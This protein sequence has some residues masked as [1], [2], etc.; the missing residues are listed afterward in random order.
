MI[1]I[2]KTGRPLSV[3]LLV[4]ASLLAAAPAAAANLLDGAR[5]ETPDRVK[6]ADNL[7]DGRAPREGDHWKTN[8]TATLDPD[9]PTIVYDLGAERD[10]RAIY[11]QGDNNDRYEVAVSN[12]GQQYSVVWTAPQLKASGMRGRAAPDL[13]ARGRY[14]R[15]RASGGDRAYAIG[16]LQ[17]FDAP[18]Q[19]PREV[20]R[21][22]GTPRHVELRNRVLTFGMA[23]IVWMVLFF[24]G[25][26]A[27][28]VVPL[29]V[30]PVFAGWQLASTLR[31]AWP[32]D[33][34]EVSLVRFTVALVAAVTVLRCTFF[35]KRLPPS[36]L[37]TQLTLAI[38]GVVG[39]LSFYRL[40]QPQFWVADERDKTFVHY[41]DLR[42]YYPVAKY[43]DEIG[44][45]Q[46]YEA[47][48]AAYVESEPSVTYESIANQQYRNLYTHDIVTVASRRMQI[49]EVPKQFSP[50]RWEAYKSDAAFFRRVMGNRVYFD[51]M[52][53]M[54]GNATPVWMSIAHVLF[55]RFEPSSTN[56][57]ITGLL[58]PLLLGLAFFF[59]GRCFGLK[60]MFVCMA[61]FGANDFIMY[62]TNWAGATLRHDWLA[63]LGL[64]ACALKSRRFALGG[65]LFALATMIRAFPALALLG[66]SLPAAWWLWGKLRSDRKLPSVAQLREEQAPVLRM[67]AAAATTGFVLFVVSGLIMGFDAWSDWY[68]KVSLLSEDPHGNHISLRSLIAG[69]ESNQGTIIRQR[70]PIF[71]GA[72]AAFA[73]AVVYAARRLEPH[74]SSMLALI[75]VPVLFYPANY[76]IHL[77]FLLPLVTTERPRAG[78][79]EWRRWGFAEHDARILGVL[80]L[81]CAAQFFTVAIKPRGLHF[82]SASVLLFAAFSA[83]LI[84]LVRRAASTP[85]AIAEGRQSAALDSRAGEADSPELKAAE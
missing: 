13:K 61:I 50:E 43:F 62:G 14:V 44:Y 1:S 11:L 4:V 55:E 2:S 51:T 33:D 82:Y 45:R 83:M 5:L 38:C 64:G 32:V 66:A 21:A 70:L 18:G 40:A 9:D 59:I 69:S 85:V 48:I 58:D 75:M 26:R 52:I 41:H 31:A 47:D 81:L 19:L 49:A 17:L 63:Y 76:Y 37:A 35:P 23:L 65:A 22:R 67:I 78:E 3:L 79:P 15:V 25:A 7:A 71:I 46:L 54:G 60:T 36:K 72:I 28:L 8:L 68:A 6:C 80:L 77:V 29:T 27:W 12:D 73:G 57:H 16:E 34:A 56:F 53:D 30:W 74:Q 39:V 42:Q 84:V 20:S 24:R 10:I